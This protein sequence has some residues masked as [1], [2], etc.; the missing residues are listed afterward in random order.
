MVHDYPDYDNQI[1]NQSENICRNYTILLRRKR[2][3]YTAWIVVLI[4]LAY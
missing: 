4:I 1:W 3:R 2:N